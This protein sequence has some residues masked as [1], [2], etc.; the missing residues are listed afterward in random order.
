MPLKAQVRA[1][2]SLGEGRRLPAAFVLVAALL[3]VLVPEQVHSARFFGSNVRREGKECAHS[4]DDPALN[5]TLHVLSWEPRVVLVKNFA[6]KEDLDVYVNLAQP[7]LEKSGLALKE[8]ENFN[9]SI[10]TSRGAFVQAPQ[11]AS[12]TI[13]RLEQKLAR[14]TSIPVENGEAWNVLYYPLR[15]HYAHHMDYFDPQNFPDRAPNNRLATFLLYIRSAE[16]G[17]ETI[18]PRGGKTGYGM[19]GPP[20]FDSCDRGLKVKAEPGDGVLFYSQTTDF[21]LDPMSLHGGCPVEEGEKW[22][23]TKWMHNSDFFSLDPSYYETHTD[24]CKLSNF[25]IGVN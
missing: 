17:G 2:F 16:K 1:A 22:V 5:T 11:D 21:T 4:E 20:E 3:L 6:S 10:R 14:L 15:G 9:G 13:L 18:F 7:M 25:N 24:S 8:G 23:A 19:K 12:G